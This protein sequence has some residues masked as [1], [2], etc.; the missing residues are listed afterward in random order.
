MNRRS[1]KLF[2]LLFLLTLGTEIAFLLALSGVLPVSCPWYLLHL[3]L[4]FPAVPAFFLQLLL[5][6]TCLSVG[7]WIPLLL[8]ASAALLIFLLSSASYGWDSL[9]L[10]LL[11]L[12]CP[13]PTGG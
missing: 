3:S 7:R 11:L 2:F 6:R 8:L 4:A 1:N 10:G 13:A 12:F 5:C 9:G